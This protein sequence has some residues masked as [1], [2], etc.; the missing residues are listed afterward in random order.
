MSLRF[1]ILGLL[2][3]EELSGY[4][5]TKRFQSSVVYF[6]EAR[7]QQIYPELTRMEE[8]GLVVSRLIEQVGRPDKR[9]YAL[10][11]RGLQELKDWVT[12]PS[13]LTLIKDE[14]MLKVY[15]YGMA[16]LEAAREA[17]VN[18]RRRHEDRLAELRRLER[19]I[20]IDN[21]LA[22]PDRILGAY[23]TLQ[24][25]IRFEEAIIAWCR[26]TEGTLAARASGALRQRSPDDAGSLS[27]T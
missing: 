23:L 1:A 20:G 26:E 6:W 13:P 3:H 14:F 17:V 22:V 19:Q 15:S 24:G 18:Q 11:D 7:S 25:G 9:L 8:D 27:R 2:A 21:A 5:L 10:T 4:E 16:D 12:T